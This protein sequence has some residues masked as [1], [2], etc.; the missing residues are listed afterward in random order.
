[1]DLQTF[2]MYVVITVLMA[3]LLLFYGL[4][5]VVP[6]RLLLRANPLRLPDRANTALA[7]GIA[8][9]GVAPAYDAY[10]APK[11]IYLWIVAGDTVGVG[12][13]L[14]SFAATWLII[15]AKQRAF[16]RLSRRKATR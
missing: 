5:F 7:C 10:R 11:S 16:S 2:L 3:P 14:L 15:Y 4:P 1:M 13:A 9:L 6:A 12:A 8:A